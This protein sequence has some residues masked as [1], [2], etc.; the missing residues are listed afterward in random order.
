MDYSVPDQYYSN[1]FFPGESYNSSTVPAASPNGSGIAMCNGEILPFFHNNEELNMFPLMSSDINSPVSLTE[2]LG[3]SDM[4]MQALPRDYIGFCDFGGGF[5]AR[6]QHE[7]REASGC[8]GLM[9]N[10]CQ[11]YP[12]VGEN[13]GIQGKPATNVEETSMKVGRYSIEER[14]DRIL[15][16]L[17]KRNQRNFNKTI[18]YAC[19]KTLADKRVRVRG[20]FAK[21]NEPDEYENEKKRENYCE[22]NNTCYDDSIQIKYDD[23]EDWLEAAM[24]SLMYFPYVSS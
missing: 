13:W 15:R 6:Y 10:L 5:E 4:A 24:S 17:K 20:R 2:Q 7:L 9:P 8:S 18:K 21:N 14:K 1:Y 11:A 19:R 3:V 22:E 23:E 16:Y 12:G